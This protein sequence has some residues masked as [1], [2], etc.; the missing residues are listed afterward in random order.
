MHTESDSGNRNDLRHTGHDLRHHGDA[1]VRDDGARLIDLAVNVRADTPPAWLRERIVGS[2][3]GLASYPDGRAAREAVAARHGLPTD[4][5]LLTAGAAEAFVLLARALKV[6]QPVVVHPQF[7]EP[8]AALRDAGHTVDRVLLRESDGFRLDPAAVPEDADLVVIG[9]PTNPTSVLHPA[10]SIARLARPGRT[11]V[12]DEAFM[13]AVPGEREAL[14]GRTDVPGLVVL[15]SLTKTWGLAGLRIGYVLAA[16]GT[17]TELERAQPLWPVSTPAL[18]A[19]EACV[20]DRALAEAAEAAGRIA[21]DRAH[22]VAGLQEFAPDGLVVTE[23]AEGPFVLVRLPRATA[24]RR[25]LRSLGFA[26]RRGDTFPGLDEEWLRLAVRDRVTVNGFL[27][28]LDR[29][30][31]LA[32]H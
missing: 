10:A 16:P 3:A 9:N 24:V 11:L 5:V 21:A 18:A 14:A 12:V 32:D 27:Q 28:A 19:A 4:R 20:S 2:L 25:H 13:D 29:A 8:E 17:I 26:V 22:L 6:R 23:P 30:M 1:E 31:T 7:T 15:R